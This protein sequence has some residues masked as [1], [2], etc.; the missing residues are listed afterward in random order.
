MQHKFKLQPY[1]VCC[2]TC[3][4]RPLFQ[5]NFTGFVWMYACYLFHPSQTYAP[6]GT[7]VLLLAHSLPFICILLTAVNQLTSQFLTTFLLN[8]HMLQPHSAVNFHDIK[9]LGNL[10]LLENDQE[11]I[12]ELQQM[13]ITTVSQMAICTT[14]VLIQRSMETHG[15]WLW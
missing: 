13:T 8:C 10:Y 14:V 2:N 6:D 3:G 7:L 15:L 1:F 11:F 12:S 4:H 9:N 5:I